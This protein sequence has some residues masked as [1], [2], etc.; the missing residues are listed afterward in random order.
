MEKIKIVE[1][2]ASKMVSS[3][4]FNFGDEAMERFVR[5]ILTRHK[6]IF[7]RDF[8]W[9]KP[10][11][12]KI[13]WYVSI[14]N[15]DIDT[16]DFEIVDFEGGFYAVATAIDPDDGSPD[17]GQTIQEVEEWVRKSD[18]FELDYRDDH[19]MLTHMPAPQTKSIMGY[20]QL[21]IFIP[22]KTKT[23]PT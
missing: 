9:H 2:P 4:G 18:F 14:M 19:Q 16:K 5:D 11:T 22:I 20:A 12:G 23:K 15:L 8:M 21:E 13:Y 6:D 1:I 3:G 7:P 17:M 10:S